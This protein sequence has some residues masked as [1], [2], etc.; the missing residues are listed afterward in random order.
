MEVDGIAEPKPST[1]VD[2]AAAVR[3]KG[4]AARY[5]SRGG[6][7]LE[8]ALDAFSLEVTGKRA[9]DV[10]ASTGGFTDCLLQRGAAHVVAVDVGYGQM[11]WRLRTDDRVEVVERTN[12]RLADP[13]SLGAPFD[14]VVCDLSFISLATVAPQLRALGNGETDYVLLIKPQFEAGRGEV[15]KGGV[16]RDLEVRAGAVCSVVGALA[17]GG[18]GVRGAVASPVTGAKGNREFLAWAQWGS[19]TMDDE[20]LQRV[21]SDAG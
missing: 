11:H 9:V 8:K 14:V 2:A 17:A 18:L 13:A 12:I 16:V 15:G 7:K 10:G 6:L 1:L 4:P 20:E 21:V 3:L 5:V 19:R